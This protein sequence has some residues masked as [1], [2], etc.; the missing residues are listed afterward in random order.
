MYEDTPMRSIG[1][2][3]EETLF[4]RQPLAHTI[5]G[6]KNVIT[7]VPRSTI[8]AY[9]ARQYRA[10][11]AVACLA[12]N[13]DPAAGASLLA[14]ALRAFPRGRA[15]APKP[16]RAQFGRERV[17]VKEKKTDQAHVMI[18]SPG[19]AFLHRDRPAVDLLAAILG[20]GMSSR[21]FLEVRERRGLAYSVRTMAE[22]FVD[23]G[24]LVTQA[25][26]DPGKLLAACRVMVRELARI[27]EKRVGRAELEKVREFIKGKLLLSLEA[28]DDVAQYAALQ[29][30]LLNRIVTPDA[31]F[32][33]LDAVG[34]A[35]IQR[36]ARAYLRPSNLRLVAI[37][38]KLAAQDLGRLLSA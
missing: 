38:P 22:Y 11:T 36:V 1:D 5:T 26:V 27:R 21:M 30:V 28:S 25:G 32:R 2:M 20:G 18:G 19:V 6:T 4:G 8:T 37:G 3:F 12:G 16:F 14:D 34:A 9:C 17:R 7:T 13:V 23:T 24:H 31:Y 35:D 33:L 10:E 15:R 29:E